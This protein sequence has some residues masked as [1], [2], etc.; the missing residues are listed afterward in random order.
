M[1]EGGAI[2]QSDEGAV[3]LEVVRLVRSAWHVRRH[4]GGPP[5]SKNSDTY[6]KSWCGKL[7]REISDVNVRF[8]FSDYDEVHNE[9]FITSGG[10]T[11]PAK[12]RQPAY[13]H[14]ANA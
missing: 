14:G 3:T 9:A 7:P 13:R 12:P 5:E 4:P 2:R 11:G 8:R 10:G 6:A 1:V